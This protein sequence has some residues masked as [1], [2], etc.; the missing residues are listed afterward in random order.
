MGSG[1]LFFE[2]VKN[3]SYEDIHYYVYVK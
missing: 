2:R 3:N 1:V